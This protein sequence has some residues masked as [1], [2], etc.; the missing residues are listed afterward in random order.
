MDDALLKCARSLCSNQSNVD[1]RY[2]GYVAEVCHLHSSGFQTVL[3]KK[4]RPETCTVS[5]IH[6]CMEDPH[7]NE[8]DVELFFG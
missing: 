1:I 8:G 4:Y 3:I 2:H 6:P 7:I 5:K